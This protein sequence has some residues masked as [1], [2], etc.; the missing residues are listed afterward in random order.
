MTKLKYPSFSSAVEDDTPVPNIYPRSEVMTW[1]DADPIIRHHATHWLVCMETYE[2]ETERLRSV[3][4]WTLDYQDVETCV[5][6]RNDIAIVG[7][8][9]THATKDL[10]DDLLIIQ[11]KVFPRA[12]QAIKF[13]T[14]LTRLNPGIKFDVTG[15][16]LGGAIA[17]ETG[18]MLKLETVTFNAA[19]P[20]SN[21]VT[22]ATRETAYHIVFDIISA[23]QSPGTIR[24]DKGYRPI[25]APWAVLTPYTWMVNTVSGVIP[26]HA[27]R[28]FSNKKVGRVVPPCGENK[29]IQGWLSS[30]PIKAQIYILFSLGGPWTTSLPKVK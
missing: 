21:P 19:A 26:S 14:E 25:A 27:L 8:R 4:E 15:H 9:G 3:G 10:Y 22:Q 12:T 6:V 1:K 11:D 23:W 30:L 16:S 24:I 18:E 5:Y 2:T 20:P 28:N 7:F 17:R 29:L 13:V